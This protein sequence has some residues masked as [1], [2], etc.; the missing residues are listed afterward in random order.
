MSAFDRILSG[1]KDVLVMRED[2][3]RLVEGIKDLSAD[4][5]DHEHRLIRLETMVE[6]ARG[7]K[8]ESAQLPA[9][10]KRKS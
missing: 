6:M 8:R 5:R 2:I 1:I 9:P 4:I 7:G 3:A 10:K